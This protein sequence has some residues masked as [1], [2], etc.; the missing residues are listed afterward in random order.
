MEKIKVGDYIIYT[1]T[2]DSYAG[3]VNSID[4]ANQT[5]KINVVITIKDEQKFAELEVPLAKLKK[6]NLLNK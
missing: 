1:D 3:T 2:R 5:A 6:R 4:E